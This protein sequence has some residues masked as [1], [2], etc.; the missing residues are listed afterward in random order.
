MSTRN[1]PATDFEREIRAHI[2]LETAKLVEEGW[3]PGDAAREARR[4]FG[5]VAV[6]KE[7][8]Y[9]AGRLV[10]FDRLVQDIRCAAR[11]LRRAPV[12]TL[13]AVSSLAAG[14]GATVVTLTVR[15]TIF[16]NPPPLYRDPGQLSRVQVGPADRRIMPFGSPVPAPL[17]RIWHDTLGA[18]IGG[19]VELG[20]RD[21]RTS[22]RTDT[23]PVRA[24]TPELFALLGVDAE[25]GR[26]RFD[27]ASPGDT[28][29]A[30]LADQVWDRL[31][32]R[33]ADAIG[34]TVWIDNIPYTVVGVMP[35]RFWLADMNSPIW[36]LL[37][38]RTLGEAG[39]I[40]TI[41]R[42]PQHMTDPM[43]E[44]RLRPGLAQFASQLAADRRELL[45]RVSPI[46]GTPI[47]AQVS[48]VLPYILG[49]AV[50]L[51]LLIACAN[52]AILMIAQWTARSHEIAIRASIGGSRGRIVRSLLTESVLLASLGGI[53]SVAATVALRGWIVSRA[54]AAVSFFNLSIDPIIFVW[55]AVITLVTGIAAGMA[56]ALYETR[57]L[58][59]NPLRA[60]A[61]SDRLR[62]RWRNALVVVEITVTVA[63]LVVTTAIIDGYQRARHADLGFDTHPLLTAHVENPRGV[64]VAQ[65]LDVLR[66]VPGVAAA[67]AASTRGY[68]ARGEQ[69][70]VA[71]D[72]TGTNAVVSDQTLIG[73][74]FFTSLGVP[75]RS[76]RAFAA[77]EQARIAIV[78]ETLAGR[79]FQGNA[80]AAR[81]WIGSTPHDVV[82][83]VADYSSNPMRHGEAEPKVFLPLPQHATN[84]TRLDFLIRAAGDP[85]ALTQTVRREI[86]DALSGT[87]V[88]N[89]YTADQLLDII[90]QEILVGMAPLFPLVV[91]GMLLTMAGVYGVV[92]FAVTRRARELAIRVAVGAGR[93]DLIRLVGGQSF[94]L[95]AIGSTLGIAA[96]FA[97]SRLVR[98][99]GGAGTI[100]D[101]GVQA[102]SAPLVVVFVIGVFATWFPSRRAL[103]INPANL[104]RNE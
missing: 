74:D 27:S 56:P 58:H 81:I 76:G 26:A 62:Q 101:P 71:V 93:R 88:T 24:I 40:E 77:H 1:R 69:V 102:F 32:G 75:M 91:I 44:A 30:V 73:P 19:S 99:N 29:P 46:R 90:G 67:A 38:E 9:D 103:K 60:L 57:R 20:V 5:N 21:V 79:L 15:N 10:W 49:I 95:I 14:I 3:T 78:N 31:F 8:F 23:A 59:T 39:S 86:R 104:L 54:G 22:E 35:A 72:A 48:F 65:V 50:L 12:V 13:V 34:E 66:N 85:D 36:T 98:A 92:A 94:R 100:W 52:V 97:L 7:R 63:L 33:R 4:R 51:T 70:Q 80:G 53:A 83:I 68:A 96:T 2:E 64:P 47:G 28:R 41:V 17:F 18:G 11:S 87:V 89:S 16:Y 42:R 25:I 45:M 82:G 55:T 6:A 84:W 43:L 61:G 37:D